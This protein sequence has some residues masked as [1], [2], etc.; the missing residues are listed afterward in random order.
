MKCPKD[1]N[2]LTI[3]YKQGVVGYSCDHCQGVF[4]T[5]KGTQAFKTNYQTAIV[6]SL[7]EASET[8][9]SPLSCPCCNQCMST[10]Y[11]EDIELEICQKC[12]SVWFDEGEAQ[13][14]TQRYGSS[15]KSKFEI[16][17]IFD[18]LLNILSLW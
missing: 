14:I 12:R 6:E 18:I 15:Q 13:S 7:F 4:L 8:Y 16:N 10:T 1:K 17:G 2:I 5:G 3:K 9:D 11:I